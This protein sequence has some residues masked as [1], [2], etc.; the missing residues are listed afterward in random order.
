MRNKYGNHKV[1]YKG[2]TYDSELEMA[3]AIFLENRQ[4]EGEISELKRQVEYPLIPAQYKQKIKHLKTKDKVEDVLVER[5]CSYKADFTYIR[6]GELVV[7]DCKGAKEIISEAAKIKKKLLL[8]VHNIE[9]KYI[10][11][12]T[13]WDKES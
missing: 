1:T 8:W 3:R 2:E 9:L 7:E 13:Q 10:F 4:K 5:S 11:S 6:N 12:P